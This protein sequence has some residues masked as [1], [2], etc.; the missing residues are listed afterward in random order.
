MLIE[1]YQIVKPGKS[2][3]FYVEITYQSIK[4]I[5]LFIQHGWSDIEFYFQIEMVIFQTLSVFALVALCAQGKLII[6]SL[7]V[8]IQYYTIPLLD[9][10]SATNFL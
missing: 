4:Q 2:L 6:K 8:Q 5:K 10:T 3:S 9:S 1:K 7:Q